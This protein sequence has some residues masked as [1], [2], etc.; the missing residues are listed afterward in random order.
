MYKLNILS[1]G[2][3]KFGY[4][5]L[6]FEKKFGKNTSLWKKRADLL[7]RWEICIGK[8]AQ[9]NK[10]GLRLHKEIIDIFKKDQ[11]LSLT[12]ISSKIEIDKVRVSWILKN[13]YKRGEI[14]RI[15]RGTYKYDGVYMSKKL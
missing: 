15:K 10:E 6:D 13:M 4:D 2:I 11:T 14:R 3:T 9:K 7:K 5:I 12:E 1:E 8:K